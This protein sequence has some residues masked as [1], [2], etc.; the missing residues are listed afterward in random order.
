MKNSSED[1]TTFDFIAPPWSGSLDDTLTEIF[2]RDDAL[3]DVEKAIDEEVYRLYGIGDEDRRAIE[4]EL[5]QPAPR[6]RRQ[7]KRS[8]ITSTRRSWLCAGSAMPWE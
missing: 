7:R 8:R 1:E 6:A 3:E 2:L 4:S 5:A